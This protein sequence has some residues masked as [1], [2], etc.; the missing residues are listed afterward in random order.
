MTLL[1]LVL[2]ILKIHFVL[3]PELLKLKR[4]F[5]ALISQHTW[6]VATC[7]VGTH[8]II[9]LSSFFFF[10]ISF[11]CVL[12]MFLRFVDE[13]SNLHDSSWLCKTQ[14]LC[15]SISPSNVYPLRVQLGINVIFNFLT[16]EKCNSINCIS[17]CFHKNLIVSFLHYS[18][19]FQFIM[20]F[21]TKKD[22][23]IVFNLKVHIAINMIDLFLL[24]LWLC[25]VLKWV[26]VNTRT[27]FFTIFFN[28]AMN[29]QQEQ[30]VRYK[31][32]P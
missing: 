26:C 9:K 27:K 2:Q 7:E 19:N 13:K 31:A 17:V 32:I 1:F 12:I 11:L 21:V 10:I 25:F 23:T 24:N 14:E 18:Q 20:F 29:I 22:S 4:K 3:H 16:N 30:W 15:P 5:S 8:H 6:N 28:L